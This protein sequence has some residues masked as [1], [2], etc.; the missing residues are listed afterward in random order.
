MKEKIFIYKWLIS[1]FV[2]IVAAIIGIVGFIISY[3]EMGVVF[4]LFG[5]VNTA[6]YAAFVPHS[7][8]FH[9][10]KITALYVFKKQ[11]VKYADIRS[12]DK[13]ESG[14]RNYPWGAYYRVMA[15]K[16]FWREM[17]IP[18]TKEI[19]IQVKNHIGLGKI[20]RRLP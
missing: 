1:V 18:S 4:S 5:V 13:E 20:K 14:I 3:V 8:V 17:K 15:D 19:D 12:C 10:K 11:E 6:W 7:F 2:G 16:P 9:S